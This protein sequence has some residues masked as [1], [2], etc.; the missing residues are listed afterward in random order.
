MEDDIKNC[1]RFL[2]EG[3]II[4]YPTD[5]F[6]GIGCDATNDTAVAKIFPLKQREENKSMIILLNNEVDIQKYLKRPSFYCEKTR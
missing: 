5:T 2:T 6:W 3:E 4:L 1:L